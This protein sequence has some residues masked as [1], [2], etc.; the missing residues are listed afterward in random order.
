MATVALSIVLAVVAL[1]LIVRGIWGLRRLD[2]ISSWPAADATVIAPGLDEFPPIDGGP[3]HRPTLAYSYTIDGKTY[4]SS[5]LG[6]TPDAFDFF[7]Q[8]LAHSF[9]ARYPPGSQVEIRVSPTDP[10]FSVVDEGASSRK[11]NHFLTLVI[12]GGLLIGCIVAV[13]Y[14]A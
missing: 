1:L 11:R 4:R 5:R 9:V 2:H 13:T 7:S 6:I 8:E 14:V 10:L 3:T 12:S